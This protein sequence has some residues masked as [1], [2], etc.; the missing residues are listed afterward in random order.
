M[1]VLTPMS[2]SL[3]EETN[4]QLCHKQI[5]VVHAPYSVERH[6]EDSVLPL[7]RPINFS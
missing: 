1:T 2:A 7:E 4:A 3:F 6:T 5:A